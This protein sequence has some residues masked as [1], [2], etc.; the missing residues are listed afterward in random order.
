MDRGYGLSCRILVC[1][2]ALVWSLIEADSH[3]TFVLPVGTSENLEHTWGEGGLVTSEARWSVRVDKPRAK[4]AIYTN[5]NHMTRFMFC[6]V[7]SEQ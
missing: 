6:V 4:V 7:F 1:W 5:R 2:T 3:M